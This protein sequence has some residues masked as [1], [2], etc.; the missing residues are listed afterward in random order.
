MAEIL[1][2]EPFDLIIFGGTGD[3]SMRK[4]LPALFNRDRDQQFSPDSR[5]VA[6]SR[7]ELDPDAFLKQVLDSLKEHNAY[8]KGDAEVWKR[9]AKRL[10][11]VRLDGTKPDGWEPIADL[12]TQQAEKIRVFYLATSP[13]IYGPICQML[14]QKGLVNR[15]GR[16]VLEKPIGHDLVSAEQ[17]NLEVGRV[18]QEDQVYRIDHY[19]GKE[20]VQNLITLRFGNSLFEP[21]W[22]SGYIDH[23]QITVAE[24][25]GVGSRGDYYDKMGALRDMVQN[26]ILQM[27][28]LVAM[29]PP[30][31]L[32]QDI[33]R[34]EKI[35]VLRALRP[36]GVDEVKAKTVI[37][38]Y[39]EG[40]IGGSAVPGYESELKRKSPTETFVA[41]KAE[42]DNWRWANVPFYLRTGKRLPDRYS[43]IVIQFSPVK[44]SI[45]KPHMGELLPN[46]LNIR[47]QPNDGVTLS[48]MTKEPGPGGLRIRSMPLNLTFADAFERYYNNAYERLLMEVVRGNP[49]LFMRRDEVETAW[50]WIDQI[51]G[52]WQATNTKPQPYMAGSWGPSRSALLM[53]RD[54]RAWHESQGW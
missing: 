2:V 28:C 1:P 42:I 39:T 12:F 51:I 13:G 43:E 50:S 9:F 53:D 10:L 22:R 38:Q 29:E 45:F 27:L 52:A 54:H 35:K 19:L 11:Y 14:A 4:L 25:I 40:V 3:L 8:Q 46:T 15:H 33:I 37:G 24:S 30:I 16:V 17:I 36:I 31:S 5:I 44:H 32:D 47:L 48:M 6:V 41:I 7:A 21:L 23:V 26:H 20:S 49:A 18:F 34:G